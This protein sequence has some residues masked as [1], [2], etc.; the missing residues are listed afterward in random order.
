MA[1][2]GNGDGDRMV[3]GPV[4]GS[5]LD[6]SWA[7]SLMYL[8]ATFQLFGIT[9]EVR[10]DPWKKMEPVPAPDPIRVPKLETRRCKIRPALGPAPVGS[11]SG[12]GP[13]RLPSLI[14]PNSKHMQVQ[15]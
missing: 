12:A 3:W 13:V 11:A 10:G 9:S 4:G 8:W 7:S 5:G 15:V 6:V 1:A 2:D 14:R